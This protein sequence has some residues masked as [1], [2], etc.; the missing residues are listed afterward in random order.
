MSP[1][2]VVSVSWRS[3][4]YLKP[5][6]EN[7]RGKA[8]DPGRLSVLLIDNTGGA[9]TRLAELPDV[10]I[11]PFTHSE[12]NGSRAHARAL[13]FALQ[14]IKTEFAVVVDP[15]I[16]VFRRG[17]DELCLA[18]LERGA[19][20][21]I[22]APYPRWKVGKYHD[23]PSPPFCFFRTGAVQ[24]LG[25]G[26]TPFGE[27][28]VADARNFVLRQVGRLGGLLTRRRYEQSAVVRRYASWAERRLGVF[29]PDTGWRI[30]G[31]ARE[32]GLRS[33]LFD[34][35]VS[36]ARESRPGC[37]AFDTLAQ[38]YELYTYQGSLMLTHKYGSGAAPWRTE[39]GGDLA[40]WR[41]CIAR[42][43]HEGARL[44]H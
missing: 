29:G 19:A 27:T 2:T 31:A 13:D 6:L 11:V 22:G 21:A 7:L 5:L 1:I 35:V 37:E 10:E 39:R 30:A 8:R 28:R 36:H 24:T 32:R 44:V 43:E 18:E 17:W 4:A 15:D 3:S 42:L 20:V 40:Y 25:A 26:W 38:H 23:F 33:I 14:R 34:A 16:Y 12:K 41:D 9:D